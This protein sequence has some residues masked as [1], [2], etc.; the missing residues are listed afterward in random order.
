MT[1]QQLIDRAEA[2]RRRRSEEPQ[3]RAERR[4]LVNELRAE[5]MT[6]EDIGAILGVSR[7]RAWQ[8]ATGR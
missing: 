6:F 2:L 8:I 1:S 4:Q 3:T 7:Q 5:G